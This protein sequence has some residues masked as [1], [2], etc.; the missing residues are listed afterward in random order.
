MIS[1]GRPQSPTWK[2]HRNPPW[3]RVVLCALT[4]GVKGRDQRLDLEVVWRDRPLDVSV[5]GV[6]Y[7]V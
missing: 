3:R 7:G 2:P 1:Q 6:P 5:V 4:P